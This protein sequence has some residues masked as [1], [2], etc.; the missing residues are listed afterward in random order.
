[1]SKWRNRR[2]KTSIDDSNAC[3]G[4]VDHAADSRDI[5][6]KQQCWM[7]IEAKVQLTSVENQ[8]DRLLEGN[9]FWS[10]NIHLSCTTCI[11]VYFSSVCWSGFSVKLSTCADALP[12]IVETWHALSD[13]CL[14]NKIVIDRD[15]Y[16]APKNWFIIGKK[17]SVVHNILCQQDCFCVWL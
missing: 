8:I 13:A 4:V 16:A 14:L 2:S 6:A 15:G 7:A 9:V 1:M 12:P 11:L 17:W 3:V 5:P 10:F